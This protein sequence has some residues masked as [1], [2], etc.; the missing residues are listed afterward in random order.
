MKSGEDC[1]ISMVLQVVQPGMAA[2]T[3]SIIHSDE[4]PALVTVAYHAGYIFRVA[5]NN[6]MQAKM[7]WW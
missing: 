4:L 3:P 5:C 2:T 6:I 7:G 1:V